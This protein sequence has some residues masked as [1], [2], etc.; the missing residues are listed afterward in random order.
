MYL[1]LYNNILKNSIEK[2]QCL[3][4]KFNLNF[5]FLK[6]V[7]AYHGTIQKYTEISCT[8]LQS[9]FQLLFV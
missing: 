6:K 8:D 7:K 3:K 2:L 9:Y 4:M 5:E 1:L